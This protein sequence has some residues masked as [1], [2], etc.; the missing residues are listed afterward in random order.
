MSNLARTPE[1]YAAW[2]R[3]K[4]NQALR[5]DEE[6]WAAIEKCSQDLDFLAA[7][8]RYLYHTASSPTNSLST[9]RSNRHA[10]VPNAGKA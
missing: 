3:I 1:S 2:Q 4:R 10:G 6:P 7:G 9:R 5:P 8:M